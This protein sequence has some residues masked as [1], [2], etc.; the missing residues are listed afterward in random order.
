MTWKRVAQVPVS[1]SS[2]ASMFYELQ[3]NYQSS[4]YPVQKST[5]K[6]SKDV[7]KHFK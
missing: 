4:P 6:N 5:I 2:P 3:K 1:L 7:K